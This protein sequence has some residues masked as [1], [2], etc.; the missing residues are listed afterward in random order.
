MLRCLKHNIATIRPDFKTVYHI[1]NVGLKV[2]L[3][4]RLLYNTF[5]RHMS[6]IQNSSAKRRP[7]KGNPTSKTASSPILGGLILSTPHT[8]LPKSLIFNIFAN[9]PQRTDCERCAQKQPNNKRTR[10]TYHQKTMKN[11][12]F[13]WNCQKHIIKW[14]KYSRLI[15]GDN[16]NNNY[17]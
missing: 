16:N 2:C 17:L 10:F 11:N 5:W 15:L 7:P 8:V 6:Q 13:T 3:E 4:M 1:Y 14:T 9:M 12:S